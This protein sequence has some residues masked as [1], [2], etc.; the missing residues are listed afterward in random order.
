MSGPNQSDGRP[1]TAGDRE[2]VLANLPR[3]RPGRTSPR[4]AAARTS[5][6][7]TSTDNGSGASV[8]AAPAKRPSTRRAQP[9][10]SSPARKRPTRPKAA[11]P[12]AATGSASKRGKAS[13][14]ARRAG[15]A[16]T[17]ERVPRQGFE[18]EADRARGPV[19]P[20]GGT[21]LVTSAVEIVGELA[22][23]GLAT[24]ERLLK[25]VFS[26]LSPS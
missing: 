12:K 9:G 8:S 7:D 5:S 6:S 15:S 20:P 3:T 18:T 17:R 21:E 1:E 26:R 22:K 13:T 2:S 11:T 10:G 4:R 25:D 19:Q 23:S 14:S 24:G 16:R